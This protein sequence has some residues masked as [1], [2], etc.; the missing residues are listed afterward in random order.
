MGADLSAPARS[1]RA[2]I[3]EIASDGRAVDALLRLLVRVM[4]II[5][6]ALV[7]KTVE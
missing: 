4:S 5:I 6:E 1:E 2:A 3:L 7:I